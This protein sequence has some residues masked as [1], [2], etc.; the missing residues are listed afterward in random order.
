MR[1]TVA[2]KGSNNS[3]QLSHLWNSHPTI[4]SWIKGCNGNKAA[5]KRSQPSG[6]GGQQQTLAGSFAKVSPSARNSKNWEKLTN[7]V[8]FC[9]AKDIMPIYSVEKPRFQQLLKEFNLQYALPLHKYFSN[10]AIPTL[11]AKTCEKVVYEIG[12]AQCFFAT[13][14]L[15]STELYIS[16]TVHFT[17]DNWELQSYC[18]QTMYCPEDHTGENL[19]SALESSLEAWDLRPELQS[20]LTTDNGSNFIEAASLLEWPHIPCFGHNLHLAVTTATEDSRVPR[21]NE[22]CHKIVNTFFHSGKK[23]RDL[24]Q[25]QTS[26]NLLKHTLVWSQPNKMGV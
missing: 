6:S 25:V 2:T 4:Y 8:T 23:R 22:I 17:G 10:T 9:L 13:T 20:Y 16:Y 1:P 19:A 3:N 7:A 12:Q 18:L 11:Y 14:H 5:M 24:T 15:W 21:A 26:L